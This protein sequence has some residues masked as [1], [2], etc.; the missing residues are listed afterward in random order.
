M[1]Q[2]FNNLSLLISQE[3]RT[4]RSSDRRGAWPPEFVFLTLADGRDTLFLRGGELIL[5]PEPAIST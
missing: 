2:F 3:A 5:R 1:A 4:V